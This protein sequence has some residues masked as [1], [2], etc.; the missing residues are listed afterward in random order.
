MNKLPFVLIAFLLAACQ[1]KVVQVPVYRY[2]QK[3]N[4]SAVLGCLDQPADYPEPDRWA[5]YHYGLK[6][7]NQDMSLVI[8]HPQ[9]AIEQGIDGMVL[10]KFVVETDGYIYRS[11]VVNSTDEMF[12]KPAQDA[13][14]NLKQ[15]I[16]ALIDNK[17]VASLYKLP[18]YFKLSK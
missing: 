11:E 5:M 13:L 3:V 14:L 16:P 18:V 8:K 1:K 12:E 6:G 2:E 17:P 10:L 15:W 9:R 7:F 4:Y